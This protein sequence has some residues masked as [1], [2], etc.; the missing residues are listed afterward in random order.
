MGMLLVALPPTP[1]SL[2][3]MTT[4]ITTTT[5]MSSSWMHLLT[6]GIDTSRKTSH[7]YTLHRAPAVSNALL[8]SGM[9]VGIRASLGL[10]TR[11]F[12]QTEHG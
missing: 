12:I 8:M 9:L 5:I 11:M 4:T 3:A 10:Q 2:H 1:A 6:L 7:H